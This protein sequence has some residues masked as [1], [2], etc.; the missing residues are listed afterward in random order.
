MATVWSPSTAPIDTGFASSPQPGGSSAIGRWWS[1]LDPGDRQ[2][3]ADLN[4]P[5]NAPG[6][7]VSAIP[8]I[9][10]PP[11]ATAP[12]PRPDQIAIPGVAHEQ[13]YNPD[14]F[15]VGNV[16]SGFSIDRSRGSS[17]M[18]WASDPNRRHG[19]SEV[20][21][22]PSTGPHTQG[23]LEGMA[24]ARMMLDR[25]Y[26][27]TSAPFDPDAARL[28]DAKAKANTKMADMQALDPVGF[29][30]MQAGIPERAKIGARMEA[31]HEMYGV[32]SGF[33]DRLSTVEQQRAKLRSTP[34]YRTATPEQR[35]AAEAPFDEESTRIKG[36]MRMLQQSMG[37]GLGETPSTLYQQQF[38]G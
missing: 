16:R 1:N 4:D 9:V 13:G 21:R 24:N 10:R 15:P 11:V 32:L 38:G 30:R 33:D 3:D 35:A 23:E 29:A 34:E 31:G 37:M 20:V 8:A 17:G 14:S 27:P 12:P 18:D 2:R 28:T 36:H 6:P 22:A 5:R 19:D 26:G 25:A 7:E